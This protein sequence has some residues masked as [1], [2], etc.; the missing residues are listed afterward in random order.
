MPTHGGAEVPQQTVGRQMQQALVGRELLQR[1]DAAGRPNDRDEVARLDL[2]V[3]VLV[4][5]I[6]HVEHALEREAEIVDD[7]RDRARDLVGR[8]PG[9]PQRA[10]RGRLRPRLRGAFAAAGGRRPRSGQ[11]L[12]LI[13][14]ADVERLLER[15]VSA[16]DGDVEVV[17][18]QIRDQLSVTIRHDGI[19]GDEMRGRAKDGRIL[20]AELDAAPGA[21][22]RI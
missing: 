19:D 17:A 10:R 4:D 22:R 6:A 5:G 2:R 11:R 1:T 20:G 18:R 21:W 8:G 15:L 7:E 12:G 3:D 14:C 16:A 9:R 13:L